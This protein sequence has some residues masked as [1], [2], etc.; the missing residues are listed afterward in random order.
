M[1]KVGNAPFPL[2]FPEPLQGMLGSLLEE[3]T[4]AG[5]LSRRQSS[6]IYCAGQVFCP[7]RPTYVGMQ[8]INPLAS[9]Q[10]QTTLALM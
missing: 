2:L 9:S 1:A 5:G 4:P 7:D 6:I 8:L 3:P 10:L